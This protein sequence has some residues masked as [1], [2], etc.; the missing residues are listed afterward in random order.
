MRQLTFCSFTFFL[1]IPHFVLSKKR[2]KPRCTP[3]D[4]TD[5]RPNLALIAT[6]I[7]TK[8]DTTRL[9]VPGAAL[10]TLPT[11]PRDAKKPDN[12]AQPNTPSHQQDYR[13]ESFPPPDHAFARRQP[14]IHE[15]HLLCRHQGLP[16][17]ALQEGR[18]HFTAVHTSE[19]EMANCFRALITQ[20][21][22][23]AVLEAMPAPPLRRPATV[24]QNQPPEE[25]VLSRCLCL[26]QL[27][28]T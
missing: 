21:T 9:T 28:H 8:P 13:V 15:G 11:A 2:V 7:S 18:P 12:Y 24:K 16:T 3:H 10:P 17:E 4:P 25:P 19:E 5:A 27:L 26:P 1:K 6:Y 22:R 20:S 14:P 23:V